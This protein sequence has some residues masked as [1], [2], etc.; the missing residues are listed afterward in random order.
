VEDSI[1]HLLDH[2]IE[3]IVEDALDGLVLL[4]GLVTSVGLGDR[5]KGC[6][7]ESAHELVMSPAWT[8]QDKQRGCTSGSAGSTTPGMSWQRRRDCAAMHFG[9]IGEGSRQGRSRANWTNPR[10]VLR[11]GMRSPLAKPGIANCAASF[12]C[13]SDS[14]SPSCSLAGQETSGTTRLIDP[15]GGDSEADRGQPSVPRHRSELEL[16]KDDEPSRALA[17]TD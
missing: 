14:Q 9:W 6:R 7:V 4:V 13:A 3:L 2:P 8:P 5:N 16:G 15:P 1:L 12:R 17:R 11:G 10:D